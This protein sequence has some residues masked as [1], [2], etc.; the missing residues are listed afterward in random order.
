LAKNKHLLCGNIL[1]K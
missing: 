1:V